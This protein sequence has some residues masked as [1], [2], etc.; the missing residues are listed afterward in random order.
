M[1]IKTF[2]PTAVNVD[3]ELI[4]KIYKLSNDGSY[5]ESKNLQK[6]YSILVDKLAEFNSGSDN[7]IFWT[8][9]EYYQTLKKKFF[10]NR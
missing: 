7:I 6:K 3:P 5:N 9:S 8:K 2:M 10:L 4:K 1:G